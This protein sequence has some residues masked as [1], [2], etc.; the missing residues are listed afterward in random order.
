MTKN[1]PSKEK[2]FQKRKFSLSRYIRVDFKTLQGRITI[3]FLL[4]GLFSIIMLL[5]SN[6]A[7]INQVNKA[8]NLIHLNKNSSIK[9]SE[10]QQ[11][12]DLTH[13]LSF[14]YLTTN[15]DFFKGDVENRWTNDIYPTLEKLDSLT[16]NIN[17]EEVTVYI[18]KLREHLPKIRSK[19]L[20][21]INDSQIEE[22]NNE[23]LI[24]D[25]I[26][27]TFLIDSIK[28]ELA[29]SETQTLREL[30][31]AE[32]KIPIFL[33]IQF[34][35]A[36]VISTLIALYI[37][38]SVLQRIK[39]LKVKIREMSEGNLPDEMEQSKD[40]MNSII[41]ALNEL[42]IN[43]RGITNFAE[44]VGK[45]QFDSE[46]AVF[47][48]KGHLGE[49]LAEMRI[50]LQ[51]VAEQDKKR[52]W[53]NAGVAKFGDI[54]RKNNESIEVL[55]ARLIGELVNYAN[56]N[57]GSL[58]IV[59][60]DDNNKITLQLKGAYAYERQKFIQKEL[61]PGQGLV[62]QCYLEKEYIY[63]SEIPANYVA[64]RSGLGEATPT[65]LL[66]SPMKINEDIFGIIE[67][68]SFHPFEEHHIE[69]IEKVGE[70]IASTIQGLKVSL[71]TK[72]LLE[73]SQMRAEQLQ[74]QEEEMRQNAEELEATQEE[75]ERQSREMGAFNLAVKESAV[76]IEMEEDGTISSVNK[77]FE[78]V[79]GY[80]PD[81]IVGKNHSY[82]WA[83]KELANQEFD[84]LLNEI[85][86]GNSAQKL[87]ECSKKNGDSIKLYADYFPIK[88]ESGKVRKIECLCFELTG[89][90]QDL[91]S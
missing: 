48:N 38:R 86:K 6:W 84:S 58:F 18:K 8:R 61:E 30:E 12:V 65:H 68:A 54:L 20:S 34:I 80:N 37:I 45:G 71:E 24:E 89:L 39:F 79:L 33:G 31:N 56:A 81:Q 64:I 62:G 74:A 60:K 5:S 59:H 91:K 1:D 52:D 16:K 49:S 67:L 41:K 77:K 35:I 69:F 14:R 85:N 32:S 15:D 29:V 70:N 53:F 78:Q 36:L 21:A 4:M 42:V 27:L 47:D 51:N 22:L 57:Q 44:E 76:F 7:W 13:I 3:G 75:M 50:K 25:I 40:E 46:I 88:E 43:L 23:Q 28:E 63:L 17:N 90:I 2:S 26:H 72:N 83:N 19:Q 11:L 87:I 66:V 82:I 73:E 55:S 9:A 10:I